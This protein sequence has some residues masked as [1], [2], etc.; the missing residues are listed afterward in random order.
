MKRY[1][2]KCLKVLKCPICRT[3]LSEQDL[4]TVSRES[5]TSDEA[6]VDKEKFKFNWEEWRVKL[7]EL[8]PIFERQKAKGG[9][10]DPEE[11]R[12]RY[13]ITDDIVNLTFPVL[14]ELYN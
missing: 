2:S 14:F 11:E 5:I 10:I 9:L 3:P 13:L 7:E 6:V 4:S 8:Q 12:K 1:I